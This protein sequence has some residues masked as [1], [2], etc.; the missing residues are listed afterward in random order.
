MCRYCIT[1][2]GCELGRKLVQA[3]ALV[4]DVDCIAKPQHIKNNTKKLGDHGKQRVSERTDCQLPVAA[5]TVAM[6]TASA[7]ISDED[8]DWRRELGIVLPEYD[9]SH[10][11]R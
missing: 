1:V 4:N 6:D 10:Q 11:P 2:S 9:L 7:V 5:A 8:N 3:D